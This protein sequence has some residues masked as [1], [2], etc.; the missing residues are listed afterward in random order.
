MLKG[1]RVPEAPNM[2]LSNSGEAIDLK[3]FYL[4][5][6]RVCCYFVVF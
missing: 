4:S 6:G 2:I 1:K 5:K 3:F